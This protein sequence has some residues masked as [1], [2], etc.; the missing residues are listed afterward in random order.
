MGSIANC[1]LSKTVEFL[2]NNSVAESLKDSLLKSQLIDKM[3]GLPVQRVQE[4]LSEN[5]LPVKVS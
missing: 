3:F 1:T 5:Y 2:E 4:E